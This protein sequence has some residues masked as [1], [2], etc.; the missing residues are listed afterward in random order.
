MINQVLYG[1]FGFKD[2]TEEYYDVNNSFIDQVVKRKKGIPITLSVLYIAVASRLGL[3]LQGVNF[4]GHF[5]IRL[6]TRQDDGTAE[7]VYIDAFH[8]GEVMDEDGC[9]SR[10]LSNI[11][12][13]PLSRWT[14]EML[15]QVSSGQMR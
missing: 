12:F 5:L 6:V 8:A 9:I 7:N 10:L 11:Q 15:F 1:D 3:N 4:P 14:N 13:T 2:N